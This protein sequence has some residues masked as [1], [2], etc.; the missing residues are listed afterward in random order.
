MAV[1]ASGTLPY[2][3][4]VFAGMVIWQFFSRGLSDAGTSLS[5]NSN[6]ITKV[7]FPRLVLPIASVLSGF[8]DLLVSLVILGIVMAWYGI[9][10]LLN[11]LAFPLFIL[12]ALIITLG[13]SLWL[14]ALDGLYRDLRHALPLLL[15]LGMFCSPVAYTTWAIV[16]ERWR[17]LYEFNPMV[18]CLEGIRWTLFP[19]AIAPTS[20]MLFKS[21]VISMMLFVSGLL[22]FARVERTVVDRV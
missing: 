6:L 18:A 13:C 19:G 22:F 1:Q 11:V 2:A 16:P 10:P 14:A 17:W 4:A 9:S 21:I 12:L 20:A 15:Q 7:Y 3:P 8:A 5:A